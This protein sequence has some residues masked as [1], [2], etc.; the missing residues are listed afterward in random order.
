MPITDERM[1]RFWITL[2]QGVD[3]VLESLERMLGGEIFIPKLPSM[4]ITDLAEA[5]LPGCSFK[6]IGIR[7]GEKL[8]EVMIPLEE[9]RVTLELGNQYLIEPAFSFWSSEIYKDIHEGSRVS[10]NFEYSSN[11]NKEWVSTEELREIIAKL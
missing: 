1:T 6:S 3:F 4:R 7:P 2:E 5:V 9:A 10:E 8:H 11:T